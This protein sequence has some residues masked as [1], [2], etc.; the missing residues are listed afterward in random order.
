M[1]VSTDPGSAPS[2][3]WTIA[4]PALSSVRPF[5]VNFLVVGIPVGLGTAN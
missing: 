4:E 5:L 1:M 2:P 3:Q